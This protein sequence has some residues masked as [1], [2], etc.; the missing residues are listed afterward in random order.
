MENNASLVKQT[1][2]LCM[3]GMENQAN[4]LHG[5]KPN[6]ASFYI[7]KTAKALIIFH[8]EHVGYFPCCLLSPLDVFLEPL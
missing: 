5:K 1:T 4:N 2:L 3:F 7:L 6:A 8:E